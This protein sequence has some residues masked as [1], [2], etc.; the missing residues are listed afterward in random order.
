MSD[1]LTNKASL[2]ET[3]D[4]NSATHI[5]IDKIN[6]YGCKV[7]EGRTYEIYRKF[8][9]RLFE[10]GE[11]YIVDDDGKDNFSVSMLCETTLLK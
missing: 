5:R 8:G 2:I 11:M 10:N 6:F 7:T 9:N 3:E 4:E 1:Q